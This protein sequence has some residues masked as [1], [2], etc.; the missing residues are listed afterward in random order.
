MAVIFV[1]G[2][3]PVTTAKAVKAA[4]TAIIVTTGGKGPLP[5]ARTATERTATDPQAG[6]SLTDRPVRRMA[7]ARRG[8]IAMVRAD[9]LRVLRGMTGRAAMTAKTGPIVRTG[10]IV[11]TAKI[12]PIALAV[13]TGRTETAVTA[14]RIVAPVVTVMEARAVALVVAPAVIKTAAV[15]AART[16]VQAL[17]AASP[18]RRP[19][20]H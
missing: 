4:T 16:N 14:A 18:N 9:G 2:V 5:T 19:Y 10:Q 8:M 17:A 3:M 6:A 1:M 12:G 20:M 11:Q 15:T 13:R 7:S